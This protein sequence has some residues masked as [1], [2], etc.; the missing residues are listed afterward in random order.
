MTGSTAVDLA[1][2][3]SPEGV[4]VVLLEIVVVVLPQV[5]AL[6]KVAHAVVVV[7]G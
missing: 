2:A 7:C 3:V 1:V 6:V 4:V 5:V